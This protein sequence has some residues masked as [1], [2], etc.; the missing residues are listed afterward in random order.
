MLYPQ[1]AAGTGGVRNILAPLA[2]RL[3]R[4]ALCRSGIVSPTGTIHPRQIFLATP[5]AERHSPQ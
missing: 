3:S 2:L 5:Y 1:G 4:S